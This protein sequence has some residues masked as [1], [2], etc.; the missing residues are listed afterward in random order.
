MNTLK[1]LDPSMSFREA[2]QVFEDMRRWR[3]GLVNKV[4]YLHTL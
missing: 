2:C 4:E 1:N 3:M